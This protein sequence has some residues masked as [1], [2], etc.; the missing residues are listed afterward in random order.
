MISA[1]SIVGERFKK[2][3]IYVPEV[4]IAGREGLN[5]IKPSLRKW[6]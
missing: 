3:E 1:M 5:I 6:I 2:N 4:L